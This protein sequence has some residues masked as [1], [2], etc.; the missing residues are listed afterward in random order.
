MYPAFEQVKAHKVATF[1][2]AI[3]G[4][5]S[6]L[7]LGS[8]FRLAAKDSPIGSEV[9][10]TFG[11]IL[12]TEIPARAY[13][14]WGRERPGKP[15]AIKTMRVAGYGTTAAMLILGI[16]RLASAKKSGK[17][18]GLGTWPPKRKSSPRRLRRRPRKP[19]AW[20]FSVPRKE[21][22]MSYH[23]A[24][25]RDTQGMNPLGV[26]DSLTSKLDARI[27]ALAKD[28]GLSGRRSHGDDA[29]G[30]V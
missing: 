10:G 1:G 18:S 21:W 19:S 28:L 2:G 30:R 25:T 3:V 24:G 26:S 22:K 9:L 12:G 4:I 6:A 15:T 8:V 29:P 20:A 7:A 13:N 14:R 5:P 23:R 17:L 16:V 11:G 27:K